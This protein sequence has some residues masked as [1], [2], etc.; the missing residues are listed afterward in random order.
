MDS[1]SLRKRLSTSDEVV[2]GVLSKGEVQNDSVI[3]GLRNLEDSDAITKENSGI[4]ADLEG[5]YKFC[6]TY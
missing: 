1:K 6:L 4:E 2:Y 5:D 3:S